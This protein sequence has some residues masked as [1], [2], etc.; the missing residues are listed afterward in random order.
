MKRVNPHDEIKGSNPSPGPFLLLWLTTA[1]E[2]TGIKLVL[3]KNKEGRWKRKKDMMSGGII[4][5]PKHIS[6]PKDSESSFELLWYID[7]SLTSELT[8]NNAW[9]IPLKL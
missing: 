1:E 5:T 3:K 7:S 2:T 4:S 9:Y 6:P 8:C